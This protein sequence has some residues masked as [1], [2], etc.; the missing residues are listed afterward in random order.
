MNEE[1]RQ[2]DPARVGLM[3]SGD[4]VDELWRANCLLRCVMIDADNDNF[5]ASEYVPALEAIQQIVLEAHNC[6]KD[7][8]NTLRG[9]DD[10]D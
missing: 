8:S 3:I 5:R 4:V 7:Y 1:T 9:K 2:I 6:A 10:E